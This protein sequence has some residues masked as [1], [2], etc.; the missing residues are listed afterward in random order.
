MCIERL[1]DIAH[2][3]FLHILVLELDHQSTQNNYMRNG[4]G[5]PS[6]NCLRIVRRILEI[7]HAFIKGFSL[8]CNL[9]S[10]DIAV[11]FYDHEVIVNLQTNPIDP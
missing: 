1:M 10:L 2:M 4:D 3:P 7:S 9:L 5:R 6:R 11:P 8:N